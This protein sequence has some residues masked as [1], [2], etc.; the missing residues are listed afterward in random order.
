MWDSSA[1]LGIF[2]GF[3]GIREDSGGSQKDSIGFLRILWDSSTFF[4]GIL[5]RFNEIFNDSDGILKDPEGFCEIRED[6]MGF[7]NDSIGFLRIEWDFSGCLAI[8]C[9]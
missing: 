7:Y 9:G 5:Q 6:P 4:L 3:D 1:F 2:Q 8:L